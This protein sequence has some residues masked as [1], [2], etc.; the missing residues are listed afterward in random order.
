MRFR[1]QANHSTAELLPHHIPGIKLEESWDATASLP[2]NS[3]F[4]WF[5]GV[6]G[7]LDLQG[8][9]SDNPPGH[10]A[11]FTPCSPPACESTHASEYEYPD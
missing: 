3:T 2:E 4:E 7:E 10:L 8:I 9:Y 5:G 6:A 1:C 11:N